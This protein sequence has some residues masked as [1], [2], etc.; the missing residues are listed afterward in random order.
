MAAGVSTWLKTYWPDIEIVGVEGMRP[1]IH[2]SRTRGGK[3][4][5]GA[6]P[7]GPVLR[8]HRGPKAGDLPFQICRDT[9]DRI[10]TVTNAEVSHAMR[11]LWEGLR[12]I[13]EPAGAMGLAAV[14]KNREP[15]PANACWSCSAARTSISSNSASSPSPWAPPTR[16]AAPCACA[17]PKRPGTMLEA[18]GL[19]LRRHQHLGFPI[20]KNQRGG[21]LAGFHP[22]RRRSMACWPPCR[23]NSMPAGLPGRKLTG[24]LD[25]TFRA[26]PCA[27][28]S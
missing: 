9:L 1:G 28:T 20:R 6:R 13:S 5:R 24:A 26:I 23:R 10:E 18:A 3:T 27:A 7:S 2:E 22:Q 21:C 19:L 15:S 8:R 14:L 17:S 12:C 16:P 25:V 4:G 11:T